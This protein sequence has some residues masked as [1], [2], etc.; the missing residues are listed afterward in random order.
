MKKTIINIQVLVGFVL[1]LFLQSL[2]LFSPF[3]ATDGN[4][5]KGLFYQCAGSTCNSESGIL[6]GATLGLEC[7]AFI[8]MALSLLVFG[9][10]VV[11]YGPDELG[12]FNNSTSEACYSVCK[13]YA[14]QCF[15]CFPCS[16]LLSLVG[17]IVFSSDFN[18][19]ELGW[20]FY[21]CI[22]AGSVVFLNVCVPCCDWIC[23]KKSEESV[24]KSLVYD[25]YF[26]K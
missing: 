10:G 15:C 22:A 12:E 7:T 3:W 8:M 2:G 16:G 1:P 20:S 11:C 5:N 19:E 24:V 4:T 6:N 9:V 21:M 17:C 25:M 26:R 14:M 18:T 23:K 13:L